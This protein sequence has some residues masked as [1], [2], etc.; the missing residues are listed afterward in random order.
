LFIHVCAFVFFSDWF[1]GVF[2]F[3][4]ICRS[5]FSKKHLTMFSLL[6]LKFVFVFNI[7]IV[8]LQNIKKT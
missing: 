7:K 3:Q 1:G 6:F 8:H 4:K 5:Q 2:C